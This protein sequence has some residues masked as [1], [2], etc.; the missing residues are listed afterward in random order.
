MLSGADTADVA[1]R[2]ELADATAQP[3]TNVTVA[4]RFFDEA[5]AR[6]AG[7]VQSFKAALHTSHAVVPG[8]SA[9]HAL[10]ISKRGLFCARGHRSPRP[11][12]GPP[13]NGVVSATVA[14]GAHGLV[15]RELRGTMVPSSFKRCS[16]LMA[17]RR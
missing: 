12:L 6:D 9:P 4:E 11:P 10:L 15:G 8:P 14:V 3:V 16:R 17:A 13:M 5:G 2:V 7:P 1:G